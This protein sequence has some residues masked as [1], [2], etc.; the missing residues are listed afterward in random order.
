MSCFPFQL[1]FTQPHL[2]CQVS[3]FHSKRI[4]ENLRDTK[5][6]GMR[7]VH[8]RLHSVSHERGVLE[9]SILFDGGEA[10]ISS[11]NKSYFIVMDKEV[12]NAST[13]F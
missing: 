4:I 2:Y 7:N 10:V 12:K 1:V 8:L 5:C 3:F 6:L 9:L 13:T 11:R